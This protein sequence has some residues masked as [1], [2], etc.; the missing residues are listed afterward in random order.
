MSATFSNNLKFQ[1]SHLNQRKAI[2]NGP[3]LFKVTFMLM[4]GNQQNVFLAADGLDENGLQLEKSW[5]SFFKFYSCHGL[6]KITEI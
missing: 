6:G 3:V 2:N 4:H 5:P 1:K